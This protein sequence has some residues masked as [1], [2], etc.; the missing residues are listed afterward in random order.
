MKAKIDNFSKEELAQIVSDCTSKRE[1]LK[2]LGYVS[3]GSNFET[4]QRRLDE[5]NI[6]IEH[7]TGLKKGNTIK[8]VT[9]PITKPRVILNIDFAK[10]S[11]NIHLLYI[12]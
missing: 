4:I 6:S 2:K 10:I 12:F 7:F 8:P 5:Y 9:I 11:I 3:T 1:L